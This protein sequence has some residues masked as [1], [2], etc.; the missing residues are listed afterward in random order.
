LTNENA[1]IL[2]LEDGSVFY[3]DVQDEVIEEIPKNHILKVKDE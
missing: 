1:F 3:V 2:Y